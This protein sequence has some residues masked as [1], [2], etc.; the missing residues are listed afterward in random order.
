MRWSLTLVALALLLAPAPAHAQDEGNADDSA[1]QARAERFARCRQ[2]LDTQVLARLE[3]AYA[4]ANP[5]V[6]SAGW[7]RYTAPFATAFYPPPGQPLAPAYG[8]SYRAPYQNT[9]AQ[10][11]VAPL[12]PPMPRA[13]V[14]G[15]L[16]QP[17]LPPPA[18]L[19]PL[20]AGVVTG[21]LAAG[22][23]I[24]PFALHNTP[25]A[26]LQGLATLQGAEANRVLDLWSLSQSYQNTAQGWNNPGVAEAVT[27]V[28]YA[29]AAGICG[30]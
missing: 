3:N 14:Y 20:S 30:R 16:Y 2:F 29:Q 4:N 9:G 8:I 15:G 6:A 24:N 22:G 28:T 26:L 23:T 7:A 10:P 18:A 21:L 13:P 17:N 19:A 11:Y 27:L 5:A 12:T 1:A 25:P